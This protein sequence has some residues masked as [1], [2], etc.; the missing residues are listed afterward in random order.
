MMATSNNNSFP[1]GFPPGAI[2]ATPSQTTTPATPT[3]TTYSNPF[4]STLDQQAATAAAAAA[5]TAQDRT[6][7]INKSLDQILE[8][9]PLGSVKRAISNN[10]YGINFRQTGNAVPRSKN[11]YGYT[12]FTRPQL[13]LSTLNVT[14]YRGFYSL[15]NRNRASYQRYTR[16]MLDPRMG[17]P[18]GA[19]S[20]VLCPFTDRS[21][22]FISSLSNNIISMSGWPDLT[23]PIYTSPSGLYGEE[24]S[25]V[26]GV[27]NHYEAYDLDVTFKN[28]LGN[29]LIYMFYIWIKYQTL[30]VE[31]ILNPY[32][33]MIAE[34]EIDYNTR[35]YR[36][37]MDKQK[38]YVS[39]I[40]CTGA[41]FPMS[42]PTGNLFDYNSDK[43]YNT[44]NAEI[45]IRFRAMGFV[46]FEDIVKYW[47]NSAVGIHSPEMRKLLKSD[48]ST[49]SSSDSVNRDDPMTLY[50]SADRSMVK[51]PYGLTSAA[52]TTAIDT[53]IYRINHRAIPYI[54]LYTSELEW[55][56]R[57]ADFATSAATDFA[58][59]IIEEGLGDDETETGD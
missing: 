47:F 45:N 27:T 30:V 48:M 11:N 9:L 19:A 42:V 12:F 50:Y 22:A 28:T 29:P 35:I 15:L 5:E 44:Q 8:N 33:D 26:D 58:K 32:F 2:P 43:P 25:M 20:G 10:L 46:A 54:N 37:V 4:T 7:V 23:A 39:H 1:S 21:N 56:V 55:W 34:N 40:A 41:S 17:S 31:G 24:H 59:E 16:T 52:E 6:V 57:A 49:T 13:N 38:R 18:T 14:S 36:L 51:V 53:G 3:Q